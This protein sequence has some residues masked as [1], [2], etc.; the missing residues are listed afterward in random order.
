M[1]LEALF[2]DSGFRRAL[3]DP[4]RI[5]GQLGLRRGERFLDIGCGTGFLTIPAANIVGEEGAVYALDNDP[6]YLRRLA[7]KV[8]KM[9]IKN[10]VII[11]STA[12][13]MEGL[14]DRSIDKA[15]MLYSLHHFQDRER[16]LAIAHEKLAR[17]GLLL[18]IDTLK[19][20]LL[21][22]GTSPHEIVTISSEAGFNVVNLKIGLLTYRLVLKKGD[23]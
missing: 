8:A 12:E 15:I 14:P 22:H 23:T 9:G 19:S 5:L 21:G 16:A 20:R 17:N 13:K 11:H 18:I 3:Q 1:G 10:V 7:N 6:A 4:Y 2:M